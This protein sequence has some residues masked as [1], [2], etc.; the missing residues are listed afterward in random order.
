MRSTL[1]F[2][3][4]AA[5]AFKSFACTCSI[6]P[7]FT[8]KEDLSEYSFI[9]HVKITGIQE[10]ENINTDY[11]AHQMNFEIIELYKGEQI[12][13]IIVSGSHPLLKGWTSC[14]LREK[15]GDEWIIFGYNNKYYKK[16]TTG[17]CTRSKRIKSSNGYEDIRYTDQPVLK[18]QLKKLF[19]KEQIVKYYEGK[20]VEFYPNGNKQ[21]EENYEDGLLNGTRT[22]WFPN[23]TLQS[24]QTY[25]NGLKD[26]VFKWFSK[27]GQLNKIEKFKNDIPIDT[28]TMWRE[29]NTSDLNLKI[30]SDLNQVN[31]QEAKEV[32]SKKRLW[33]Q[34]I[35]NDKGQ[36]VSNIEFHQSGEKYEE[37]IYFPEQKKEIN[38]FFYENGVLRSEQF[39][40]NRKD[41]GVY[42]EW[43]E[44]G[45]L[46]RS[47]EYDEKGEI[48][49]SSIK[50]F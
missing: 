19:D 44:N 11:Y 6:K 20:R 18:T 50:E 48:I 17:Y 49:K 38:R 1:T 46:L 34:R 30:Y 37:T 41:T 31:L 40:I 29:I 39:H 45:K 43:D 7:L 4:L 13:N 21:L 8:T 16:L 32:L 24:K 27:N 36:L 33:I 12:Q 14:D 5:F 15:I 3:F 42:K 23:D 22:L 25:S 9:A 35:Y 10:A 26:G 47:W 28:T 2:I